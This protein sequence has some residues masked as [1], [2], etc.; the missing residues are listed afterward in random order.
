VDGQG[1]RRD[2]REERDDDDDEGGMARRS[3]R[4]KERTG[5]GVKRMERVQQSPARRL[6]LRFHLHF[7]CA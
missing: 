6:T 2:T 1:S 5:R 3:R 4:A 7:C